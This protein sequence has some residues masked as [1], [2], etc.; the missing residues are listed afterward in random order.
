MMRDLCRFS[1]SKGDSRSSGANQADRRAIQG[2]VLATAIAAG[3]ARMRALSLSGAAAATLVGAAVHAG[4]GTRGSVT[5]VTCFACTSALGRLASAGPRFQ[6]RGNQRD[7]V[8]VLANGGPA[9]ALSLLRMRYP[10]TSDDVIALAF[11]GSLAAAAADTAATEI[12]TR[13][14]GQPRSITTGR[15]VPAGESGAV[16]PAGLAAAVLA[17]LALAVTS[18]AGTKDWEVRATACAAGGVAGALVDS[19]LGALLQE[20]RWCDTCCVR[21]ELPV[22]VCGMRTCRISGLPGVNND[23]VNTLAIC[24]GSIATIA[25]AGVL[26][27]LTARNGSRVEFVAAPTSSRTPT[28][29][30]KA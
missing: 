14:G 4:M 12:G 8:Q 25:C 26:S 18:Q 13:W 6:R 21:T 19:L 1:V 22:H 29:L 7:A 27:K 16:T 3:A 9:A 17:S 2:L 11:F 24:A 20:Q 15:L 30:G 10:A 28:H 23:A 5:M